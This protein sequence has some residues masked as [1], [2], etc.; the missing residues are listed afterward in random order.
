M[1]LVNESYSVKRQPNFQSDDPLIVKEQTVLM[2]LQCAE[3]DMVGQL[4]FLKTAPLASEGFQRTVSLT[5][6]GFQRCVA[7]R[8]VISEKPSINVFP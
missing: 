6:K 4:F 3:I 5:A 8:Q 7:S 2:S 1:L